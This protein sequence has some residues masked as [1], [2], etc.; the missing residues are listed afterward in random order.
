MR[1][2]YGKTVLL[3]QRVAQEEREIA[4]LTLDDLDVVLKGLEVLLA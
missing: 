1:P 3:S 4:W 2:G